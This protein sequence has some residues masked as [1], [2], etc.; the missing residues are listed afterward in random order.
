MEIQGKGLSWSDSGEDFHSGLE[1]SLFS[2]VL[3]G[4]EKKMLDLSFSFIRTSS[5]LMAVA[6]IQ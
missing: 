4:R 5:P 2:V 1:I 3:S 6:S